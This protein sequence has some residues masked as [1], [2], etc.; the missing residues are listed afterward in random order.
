MRD[1]DGLYYSVLQKSDKIETWP[2]PHIV[3]EDA[4]PWI[5]YNRLKYSMPRVEGTGSNKRYD[6]GAMEALSRGCNP[7]WRKFV[8]YHCSEAFYKE[9]NH[10][11][12]LNLAGEVGMR[13]RDDT[14]IRLDCQASINTPVKEEG[15]VCIAHID[16]PE[17]KWA[18]LLYMP[19]EGDDAGGDLEIYHCPVPEYFGKRR[20]ANPGPPVSIVPYKANTFIGF[21]NLPHSVHAPQARKPT[22]FTR[23]FINFVVDA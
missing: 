7:I 3:I 21:V 13:K 12:D 11:F 17:T 10:L 16:N 15:Q 4:L 1:L 23:K 9:V 8:E 18:G 6:I 2:Y 5:L 22:D 19:D 20:V 14:P